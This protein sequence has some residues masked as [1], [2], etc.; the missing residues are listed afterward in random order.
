MLVGVLKTDGGPHPA[1][2][3]AQITAS[4]IISISSSAPDI[5]LKEAQEFENKLI[6]V[7]TTHHTNAQESERSVLEAEGTKLLA[8]D[9][10]TSEHVDAAAS[11]IVALARGT[12]FAVHFAKPEVRKYLEKLLHSHF[13]HSMLIERSWHADEHADHPDAIAFKEKMVGGIGD[14]AGNPPPVN[15]AT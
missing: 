3:W 4:Q 14:W 12:H 6:G 1:E 11:A 13:H 7:L 2:T 8:N 15:N 10:D 9:I 5:L